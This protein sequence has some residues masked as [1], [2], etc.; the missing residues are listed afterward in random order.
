[1]RG[2]QLSKKPG[3]SAGLLTSIR[4]TLSSGFIRHGSGSV[5]T[6]GFDIGLVG[7]DRFRLCAAAR[8]LGELLSNTSR[9]LFRPAVVQVGAA[10][11]R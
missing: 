2:A 8:T 1:L 6:I 10:S 5:V 11:R 3:V 4:R 9:N 7:F